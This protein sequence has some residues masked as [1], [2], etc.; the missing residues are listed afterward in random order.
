MTEQ[1]V[2]AHPPWVSVY[3]DGATPTHPGHVRIREGDGTPG[4]VVLGLRGG[5]ILLVEVHRRPL[6]RTLLELP[7]GFGDPD[8]A[9]VETAVRELREETGVLVGT[10]QL[11]PLGQVAPNGGI[12]ESVVE[13][14]LVQLDE[15]A[16]PLAPTDTDEIS[17]ARWIPVGDVLTMAA[18]GVIIDAFT[19][20]A[21]LRAL[22][23]GLLPTTSRT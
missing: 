16:Q 22:L 3:V 1:P 18:E 11:L 21:L 19:L 14:F 9:P 17:S 15:S 8:E 6:G 23:R 13:L 2:F 10:D 5:Q 7:R 12:L 4:A 20:T